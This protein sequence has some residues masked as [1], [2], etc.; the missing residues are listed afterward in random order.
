MLVMNAPIASE[1]KKVGKK[2]MMQNFAQTP[3]PS[4]KKGQS[5]S[6]ER[7]R[8][9]MSMNFIYPY[10]MSKMQNRAKRM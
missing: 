8:V 10:T 4:K 3:M 9:H 7:K 1:R 2:C 5:S 6:S